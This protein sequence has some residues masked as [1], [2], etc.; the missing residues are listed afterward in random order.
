M[1]T[2]Q[3]AKGHPQR[4]VLEGHYTRLEPIGEQHV[5]DLIRAVAPERYTYLFRN[6]PRSSRTRWCLPS[7]TAALGSPRASN[8]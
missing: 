8:R 3:P 5:P 4:V 6:P 7:L 1:S 2:P